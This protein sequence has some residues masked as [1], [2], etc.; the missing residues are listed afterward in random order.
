M[1]VGSDC[2]EAGQ[3]KTGNAPGFWFGIATLRFGAGVWILDENGDM[4]GG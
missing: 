1:E 3:K 2:G 4:L